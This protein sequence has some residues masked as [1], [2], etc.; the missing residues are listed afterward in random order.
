MNGTAVV[1]FLN[2]LTNLF[3]RMCSRRPGQ[4]FSSINLHFYA[5]H[6]S[7]FLPL[8]FTV[9]KF[10]K[11]KSC[12]RF[13]HNN[14]RSFFEPRLIHISALFVVE[15]SRCQEWPLTRC[16]HP[17][18]PCWPAFSLNSLARTTS[19]S[20]SFCSDIHASS[21]TPSLEFA[22]TDLPHEVRILAIRIAMSL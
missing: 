21:F 20:S 14:Q 12:Q 17:F 4:T 3:E 1:H 5:S 10:K 11:K 8:H 22:C 2:V 6:F 19:S 7:L 9:R 15:S 16:F 13:H 18:G